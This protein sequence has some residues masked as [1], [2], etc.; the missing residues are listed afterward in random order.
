MSSQP[1][2][3]EAATQSGARPNV[4]VTNPFGE[5][6]SASMASEQNNLERVRTNESAVSSVSSN[7][8]L[9]GELDE[10]TRKSLDDERRDLPEGWV[11]CFDPKTE[12]AFYVDE[13]DPNHRAIW[14]HPYDDPTFLQSLPDTHPANPSSEQAQQVRQQAEEEERY[15]R[16]HEA[17]KASKTAGTG[18]AAAAQ[19]NDRNW[20]QRKKD[21][22]IGT[23][24]ERTKAK[25]ARR[26][27][28]EEERRRMR[29]R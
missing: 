12:H 27:Q 2:P 8:T 26:K 4:A 11:R 21:Q 20:I 9:G 29:V 6:R 3:Y 28:K 22:L 14:V 24:E 19:D 13:K 25:E 16:E 5:T 18:T 1:P 23:K 17:R 15:K 7:G 10:D